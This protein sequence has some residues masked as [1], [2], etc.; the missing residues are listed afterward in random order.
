MTS[1]FQITRRALLVGAASAATFPARA[2]SQKLRVGVQKYGTLIVLEVSGALEKRLTPKGVAV[3]WTEFPAGPQLLEALNGGSLDFGITGEAPP[4]FAQAAGVPFVYVGADQPAP[5]GEAIL[6]AKDS[7]I[8]TVADLKGK[9]VA[10]NRGSNVH[11]LLI[12]ALEKAGLHF[13]DI[14]PAYLAPADGRA[15]FARGS[16]DAWVIWD[17][18]LAAGQAA[19]HARVLADAT[20]LANNPQFYLASSSFAK[21]RPDLLRVLLDEIGKTDDW[22]AKHQGDVAKLLA[23]HTGLSLDVLHVALAR[24]GYGV[25][26][27]TAD[28][29]ASQQRIADTFFKA[30]VLPKEIAVRD[31][32]WHLT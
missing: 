22:A 14:E 20:G 17:P 15:A 10:F 27:I 13:N 8:R 3:E 24:L 21:A 1:L 12:A 7:P 11:Y 30:G 19:T 4:V 2:Q 6:V 28:I 5:T 16:V 29:I 26:P 9:R 31:A 25:G 23:P 32:V 18:Y